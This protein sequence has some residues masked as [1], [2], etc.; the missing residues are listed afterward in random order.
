MI[1]ENRTGSLK[2][3][4]KKM[5][6]SLQQLRKIIFLFFLF[7]LV[8]P[9]FQ[10]QTRRIK[11]TPLNG[12]IVN[13][14]NIDFT[15]EN[16]FSED[17]QK[18]KE[19][20]V[21]SAFGFREIFIRFNNQIAFNL[22]RKSNVYRIVIGKDDYM[23][24]VEYI[25]SY[26]GDNFIGEDSIRNR[27]LRL[28]F[29]N[30][31][32]S[33]LNKTLIPIFASGKATFCAEYIPK[34]YKKTIGK[35][36]Y[37]YHIKL[38]TEYGLK[39]IDFQK[40]LLEIKDTSRY[41][42]FPKYGIHWSNYAQCIVADSI[43]HYIE[44]ARNIDCPELY[45][46]K[47]NIQQPIKSDYDIGRALN[48]FSKLKGPDM[49]YPEV[50]FETDST[51]VKPNVLVISDSYYCGMYHFGI[52]K[53]FDLGHFWYYAK[54]IYP[55]SATKK[56]TTDQV[57]LREEIAKHDVIIIISTE[58]TLPNMGWKFIENAYNLFYKPSTSVK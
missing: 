3:I 55:E 58:A 6:P 46:T 8:F 57:D 25:K 49:A 10:N 22:F 30:D 21:N 34:K 4:I 24:N 16:W 33:K 23:Y 19:K 40:Y 41:M 37:E 18:T 20:Y 54:E 2:A 39:H 13:P 35:T 36:N 5:V 45:W 47:V 27:I 32:L 31:T 17:Y 50:M 1:K 51:K 38:A 12:A 26:Y 11:I 43:I 53:A 29:L 7:V 28:K 56:L 44:K 14:P 42:L 48:L 9:F 15:L 52:N